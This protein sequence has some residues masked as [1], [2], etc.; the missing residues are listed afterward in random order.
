MSNLTIDE[1]ID[2]LLRSNKIISD[3]QLKIIEEIKSLSDRVFDLE[4]SILS[5]NGKNLPENNPIKLRLAN[6]RT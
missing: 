6:I 4:V 5:L 3:N 1:K 2:S